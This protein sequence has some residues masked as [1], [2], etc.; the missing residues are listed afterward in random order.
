F[1]ADPIHVA[2]CAAVYLDGLEATGRV[3]GCLKHFPGLGGVTHDPHLT[4][5]MLPRPCAEL[6]A[7]DLIPFRAL[8][9]DRPI[10]AVMVSYVLVPP[11]DSE[12]P[13]TFSRPIVRDLLQG[14][15]GFSGVVIVDSLTMGAIARRYTIKEAAAQAVRAGCDLLLGPK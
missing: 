4:L 8:L 14:T 5:A 7:L 13:A 15:L 3:V 6:E 9:A 12:A 11:L 1:G 2:A 10:A